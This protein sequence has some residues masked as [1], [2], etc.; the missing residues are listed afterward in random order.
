[1]ARAGLLAAT[2][3]QTF[4]TVCERVV[5]SAEAAVLGHCGTAYEASGTP[6]AFLSSTSGAGDPCKLLFDGAAGAWVLRG[7]HVRL[8]AYSSPGRTRPPA[9]GW[10]TWAPGQAAQ[11]RSAQGLRVPPLS[12]SLGRTARLLSHAKTACKER[13]DVP[14][15]R[16]ASA[17]AADRR[18]WPLP[19]PHAAC[20]TAV[21]VGG[22]VPPSLS[23]AARLAAELSFGDY[24]PTGR[25]TGSKRPVY[26][27]RRQL[28][29]PA[30]YLF[31]QH[32]AGGGREWVVSAQL[33]GQPI[34]GVKEASDFSR[35]Q[36]K[37]DVFEVAA[38][39][40]DLVGVDDAAAA[41][42]AAAA[43]VSQTVG[44]RISAI[45]TT[46][47]PTPAPSAAPTPAPTHWPTP[48]P[49]PMPTPLPCRTLRVDFDLDANDKTLWHNL[50]FCRGQ[51]M[52][53]RRDAHN[54]PVYATGH[55]HAPC[56]L[57]WTLGQWCFSRRMGQP[58][59]Q[60][61]NPVVAGTSPQQVNSLKWRSFD[62]AHASYE[63]LRTP[64][65]ISCPAET[66]ASTP[67]PVV[68]CDAVRLLVIHGQRTGRVM[69]AAVRPLVGV[70]FEATSGAAPA[71]PVYRAR[72]G[73]R[74]EVQYTLAK[75]G[76]RW[77]VRSRG[78]PPLLVQVQF[79]AQPFYA[80]NT[81]LMLAPGRGKR[82]VRSGLGARCVRTRTTCAPGSEVRTSLRRRGS[83]V[84][85]PAGKHSSGKAGSRCTACAAGMY[86]GRHAAACRPC[87]AGSTGRQG[88]TTA[89]CDGPCPAGRFVEAGARECA[90][91]MEG[92][93]SARS[94]A[95]A[96]A[97]CPGGKYTPRASY[98][99]IVACHS[100][101]AGRVATTGHGACE[102]PP[103]PAPS[104]AFNYGWASVDV[105]SLLQPPANSEGA[106]AS[107]GTAPPLVPV[108][109]RSHGLGTG[110]APDGYAYM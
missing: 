13:L 28:G 39:D 64:V 86:A 82:Y 94:G 9:R 41:I 90:S 17:P 20:G 16:L 30:R 63:L 70:L 1:M 75:V 93:F 59:Y 76:R 66:P 68:A 58:P 67:H 8:W 103:T 29:L 44:L 107:A 3:V 85:C 11:A 24:M 6:G 31:A 35:V 5:L 7:K 61:V 62:A 96:C 81:W 32:T 56:W 15:L 25:S 10:Y 74:K 40:K 14:T 53:A 101:P 55:K 65:R 97:P 2:V 91:C 73:L 46:L 95:T 60:L 78:E 110:A 19:P 12:R 89:A 36:Y 47:S 48:V 71:R 50:Q 106:G 26:V 45:C 108:G 102:L 38:P 37:W 21:R 84:A 23:R 87:R 79:A 69:P 72:A 83:C 22:T 88:S 4:A 27:M 42:F 49:T 80:G 100:C 57:F 98:A 52:L 105:A 77:V 34:M 109:V 99:G 51:F 43:T 18:A 104:P 92:R 54:Y 33:G